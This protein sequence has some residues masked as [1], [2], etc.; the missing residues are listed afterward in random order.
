MFRVLGN[1]WALGHSLTGLTG[2]VLAAGHSAQA[3]ARLDEATSVLRQ[4]APWFLS[5]TLY[6]RAFLA[7]QRGD[8]GEAIAFVRESLTYI[9][10]LDD[11]FAFVCTL[12]PLTAAAVLRIAGREVT[13]PGAWHRSIC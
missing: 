13:R 11:K 9:R 7:A 3:D 4:T 8:A 1:P 10:E 2:V 6:F 5:W 12:V